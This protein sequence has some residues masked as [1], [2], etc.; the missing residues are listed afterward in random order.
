MITVIYLSNETNDLE[1][2]I[3][4]A[5]DESCKDFCLDVAEQSKSTVFVIDGTAI[6]KYKI[7]SPVEFQTL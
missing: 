1:K 2:R 6:G 7:K 5:N 4:N 3:F